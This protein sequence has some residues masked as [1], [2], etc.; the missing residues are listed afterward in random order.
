M[1]LRDVIHEVCGEFESGSSGANPILYEEAFT[2]RAKQASEAGDGRLA[3]R[4]RLLAGVFSMCFG[5]G[6]GGP[7]VPL[8]SLPDG[9]RTFLPEDLT[10]EDAAEIEDLIGVSDEPVFVA[11]LADLLWITTRRHPYAQRAVHGYLKSVDRETES[12]LLQWNYLKRAAQVGMELGSKAA[13]REEVRVKIEILFER[14]RHQC[15]TP[16]L[17]AWPAALAEILIEH[18]LVSNWQ[19]LGDECIAIGGG[20]PIQ[21][22]CDEPRRYYALAATCYERA[23]RSADAQEAKLA[24]AKHW[25]AEAAQF[26]TPDG[27]AGFQIAHRLEG[28]IDAYRKAGGQRAEVARLMAELRRANKVALSQMKGIG[29]PVDVEPLVLEARRVMTG[30]IGLAAVEAFAGLRAPTSYV[31]ARA[32]AVTQ[33]KEHP[34]L[35]TMPSKIMVSEG[36]VAATVPSMLEDEAAKL[37]TMIIQMYNMNQDLLGA[38]ILEEARSILASGEAEAWPAAVHELVETSTFVPDD[39]RAIYA[40]A[41]VAG[42]EGDR[43]LFQHLIIPQLENSVRQVFCEAGLQVTSIDAQGVQEE[44]NLNQLLRL[45]GAKNVLGEDLV[46]EMRSLLVEK[47]G[48]NLRNRVCH[49][50]AADGDYER[51][52]G[53]ALLWLTVFLLL[54]Y[55][56]SQPTE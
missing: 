47:T 43:V 10:A 4:L 55:R 15:F 52:A 46:W 48:P 39:R 8:G 2:R 9:R 41:L 18:R 45:E 6:A 12:W 27:E 42:F 49:G 20:F 56:C 53:N 36:N 13:E 24:I 31:T 33:S 50:L 3:P 37:Q 7:F 40:R 28:A 22:G 30:K 54:R 32:N 38:T 19:K 35:A 44:R 17:G 29:V 34:L 25:E 14:D 21:P 26:R 5:F 1:N 16:G 51:P 23:G 11:R